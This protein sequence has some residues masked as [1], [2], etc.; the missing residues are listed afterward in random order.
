MDTRRPDHY[1]YILPVIAKKVAEHMRTEEKV[2]YEAFTSGFFVGHETSPFVQVL[3]DGTLPGKGH[4][5]L[6]ETLLM[7]PR[8]RCSEMRQHH[9]H[10]DDKQLRSPQP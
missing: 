5:V 8:M 9:S 1:L 4:F 7:L 10:D 2:L 3:F 6:T